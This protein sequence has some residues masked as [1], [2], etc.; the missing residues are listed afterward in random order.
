MGRKR[1]TAAYRDYEMKVPK[2]LPSLELPK[3]GPL[4]LRLRAGLSNRNADLDNVAKPFIDILQKAYGFNDNRI[5]LLEMTK[6]IVAKG[7]E[8]IE[9]EINELEHEPTDLGDNIWEATEDGP[10]S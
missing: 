9:F 3:R 1:K 4:G 8:Y 10:D 2:E 7:Q 6:V 5:Y